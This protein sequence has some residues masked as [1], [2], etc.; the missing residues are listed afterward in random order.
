MLKTGKIRVWKTP[1]RLD[2]MRFSPH[3]IAFDNGGDY[4]MLFFNSDSSVG[5]MCGNGARCICRYGF[6]NG[7][8]GEAVDENMKW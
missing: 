5:E 8:A 7:L 6:E 3:G 4:R 2:A 1:E